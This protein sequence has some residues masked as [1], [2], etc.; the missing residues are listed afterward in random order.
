MCYG[1]REMLRIDRSCD[2]QSKSQIRKPREN[3]IR[4]SILEIY[5]HGKSTQSLL[6]IHAQ[7]LQKRE[8]QN[9]QQDTHQKSLSS[10][11]RAHLNYNDFLTQKMYHSF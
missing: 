2:E 10:I 3:D 7:E 6:L 4:G 5:I 1:T 11:A 8:I 9:T